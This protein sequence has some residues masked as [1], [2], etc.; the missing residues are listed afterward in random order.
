MWIL[1]LDESLMM[2]MFLWG[3]VIPRYYHEREKKTNQTT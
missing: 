2:M 1:E 3:S